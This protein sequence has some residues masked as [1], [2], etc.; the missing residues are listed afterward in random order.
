MFWG[1]KVDEKTV[2]ALKK[3]KCCR[4]SMDGDLFV[5]YLH[6]Q[7]YHTL[8]NP[9]TDVIFIVNLPANTLKLAK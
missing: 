6:V 1:Y 2:S 8:Y 4:H 9:V 7:S 5:L 3:L